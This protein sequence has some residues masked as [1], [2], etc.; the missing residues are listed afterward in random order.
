[1]KNIDTAAAILLFVGAINWGFVGFF[2]F[3]LIH[4]FIENPMGDRLIYGLIGLAGIYRAVCW[5]TR[6]RK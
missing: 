2:D 3:N 5:Q 4:F 6:D 1:M